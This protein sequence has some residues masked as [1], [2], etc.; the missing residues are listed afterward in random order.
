MRAP[1]SR[2]TL[3]RPCIAHPPMDQTHDPIEVWAIFIVTAVAGASPRSLAPATRVS[4]HASAKASPAV[5]SPAVTSPA[6][7]GGGRG[8]LA[9]QLGERWARLR[10]LSHQLLHRNRRRSQT[11]DANTVVSG[12]SPLGS[13]GRQPARSRR[14]PAGILDR[15]SL[16]LRPASTPYRPLDRTRCRVAATLQRV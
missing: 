11:I 9:H 14:V 8:S 7:S 5:T 15:R 3:L 12:N 1:D 13:T 10:R 6:V 2:A 4:C 16:D